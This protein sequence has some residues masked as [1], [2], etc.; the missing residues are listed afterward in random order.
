MP[1]LFR[2]KS[3]DPPKNGG[4]LFDEMRAFE[5]FQMAEIQTGIE[6]AVAG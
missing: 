4:I 3:E 5:P 6:F 1:I 2:M